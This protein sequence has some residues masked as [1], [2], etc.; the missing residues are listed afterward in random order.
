MLVI[1]KLYMCNSSPKLENGVETKMNLELKMHKFYF[2]IANITS[3]V[4]FMIWTL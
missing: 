4:M 2:I 1:L 3:C